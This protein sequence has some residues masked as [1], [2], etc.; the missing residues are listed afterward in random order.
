MPVL[1]YSA[2]VIGLIAGLI[3]FSYLDR[4]YRELGRVTTQRIHAHLDAFEAD[5]EPRLHI[6]RRRA[7]LAFS[8]LARF[9]LVLV[10]VQTTRG[11]IFFVPGTREAVLE[12]IAWLS[13]E[14]IVAMQFLPYVLLLRAPG[15]WTAPLV[16]AI[17]FFLWMIWPVQV[18]LETTISFLNISEDSEGEQPPTEQQGIEAL[19]EAATEEGIL[20]QDEARLIEQ[21]V[22]FSD[23]RVRDVMTPRPDVIAA[24]ADATLDQFRHLVVETKFSRIPVYDKNMDDM[25]G[26]VMARDMLKVPEREAPNRFVRELVRPALFVPETKMGSELLKEMQ[27][28]NQQLAIVIDEYGLVGGIVTVEDLVEEIVGEIGEEDRPLAPDVV[29]EPAGSFVLRGSVPL[30]K[31]KDLFGIEFGE[32][33]EET[34]AATL[35]GLLNSVV[36]HVPLTGEKIDYDGLQFEVLE[37]NQRKV[38]RLRARRAAG[39]AQSRTV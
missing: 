19:V 36:G 1:L 23:K 29:R 32:T 35:A 31:L 28:K 21:V 13:I 2:G 25:I 6:E 7:N 27:R 3:L 39:A 14:V 16:P 24:Q 20:E 38:L 10:A 17:R 4:V 37:A 30:E 22:E 11:V 33:P 26:I 8:L 12:M 34:G 9:W 18:L 5:V 15:R